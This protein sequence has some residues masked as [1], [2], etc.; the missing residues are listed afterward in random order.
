MEQIVNTIIQ[1]TGAFVGII[2]AVG[3]C[4]L[5]CI[6]KLRK[7]IEEY[8]ILK[9]DKPRLEKEIEDLKLKLVEYENTIVELK[10]IIEDQNKKIADLTAEVAELKSELRHC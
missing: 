9:A 10:K 5:M 6:P 2:A 1:N 3:F 8:I 7:K 4:I